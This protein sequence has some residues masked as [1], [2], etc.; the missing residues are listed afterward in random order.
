[1]TNTGDVNSRDTVDLTD[2]DKYKR[3]IGSKALLMTDRREATEYETR[4]RVLLDQK[5]RQEQLESRL[6]DMETKVDRLLDM[7]NKLIES[8]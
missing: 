3:Q 7:M 8:K 2:T 1:M 6:T 5:K 4:R